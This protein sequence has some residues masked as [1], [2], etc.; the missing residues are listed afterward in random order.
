LIDSEGDA[1]I[2]VV[3]NVMLELCVTIVEV[4]ELD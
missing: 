2:G 1:K 3:G 4:V